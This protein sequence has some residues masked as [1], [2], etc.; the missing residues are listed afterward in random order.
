MPYEAKPLVFSQDGESRFY[1]RLTVKDQIG[2]IRDLGGILAQNE[3]S[4]ESI[5]QKTHQEEKPLEEIGEATLVMLTH[6]VKENTFQKALQQ[7][8]E[9]AQVKRIDCSLKVF[10]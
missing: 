6:Q 7:I 10:E 8:S 2:V 3:I 1:L 4:L 5:A 9:M